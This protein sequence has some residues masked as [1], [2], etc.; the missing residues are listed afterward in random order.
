MA[1]SKSIIEAPCVVFLGAGASQILGLKLMKDFVGSLKNSNPPEK[2]LFEAICEQ[3]EDLEY[4]FEELSS[5]E[6]KE[7]LTF[8]SQQ[9]GIYGLNSKVQA[10]GHG[11]KAMA[12]SLS[13]WLKEKVFTHYRRIDED[14]K[15]LLIL[16]NILKPFLHKFQ[17]LV[18]FTTNYDPVVETLC[19]TQLNCTLIDGFRN[20]ASR[21]EYFWDRDVFDKASFSSG[22]SLVLFK[23]HG[24]ANWVQ[25]GSRVSKGASMF[26]RDDTLYKNVL[27]FPATRKVAIE[28]PYFTCYDYLGKCLSNAELC[29]VI[30]YSFR[31]YDALT[32]FKAAE[33]QNPKL[34]ILVLD[35]MA[36]ERIKFLSENGIQGTALPYVVGIQEDQYLPKLAGALANV[37]RRDEASVTA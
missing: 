12:Q 27:I 4:L 6:T 25:S 19:R 31:D 36:D 11:I 9:E 28:D 15:K 3:G 18:V 7:Y 20:D 8:T 5:L 37:R 29:L 33:I 23:L 30:G 14:S 35:N 17:P 32:R 1:L 13:L 34:R 16:A 10:T 26:G 24:S 2:E 21:S 22:E